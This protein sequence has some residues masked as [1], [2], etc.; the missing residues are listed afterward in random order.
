MKKII[1]SCLL[2]FGISLFSTGV[3][4]AEWKTT[5]SKQVIVTTKIPWL[6]CTQVKWKS[7]RYSCTVESWFQSVVIMAGWIIKYFTFLAGLGAVLFIIVNGIMYSMGWID[8]S[9]KDESKK[10]IWATLIGLIL[11][12]L[13]WVILNAIAPWIYK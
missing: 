1:L 8:Q 10:R 12:L 7:D 5:T 3:V 9:L 11:L 13:S 6:E 4:S 2:F